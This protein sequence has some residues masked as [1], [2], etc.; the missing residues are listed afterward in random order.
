MFFLALYILGMILVIYLQK[1]PI[2]TLSE[3][4]IAL[5]RKFKLSSLVAGATFI[6]VTSS[7][8]YCMALSCFILKV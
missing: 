3:A 1:F 7:D 6:A 2:D 5:S 8:I 4:M